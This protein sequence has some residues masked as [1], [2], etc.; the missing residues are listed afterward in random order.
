LDYFNKTVET[1]PN[2]EA[3]EDEVTCYDWR[4][5]HLLTQHIASAVAEKSA[6][7]KPIP[8][9]MEKCADAVAAFLGI[10]TAGCFYVYINPELPDERIRRMLRVLD[11]DVVIVNER[12][13]KRL[14]LAGYC[15]N[16]LEIEKAKETPV[17]IEQLKGRRAEIQNRD[18][19]YGIFTSGSTGIPKNVVV[20]HQAVLD[21][22]EDFCREFPVK[23]QDILGNQAPFDFDVSVKDIY[24]SIITGAKLVL[25][26]RRMFVEPVVLLDYL[27]VKR[28]TVLIWAASALCIVSRMRG[29]EYRI[30]KRVRRVM[31]SGEVMPQKQLRIW[32][33]ALPDVEFVNLYG[34][35]EVTCNC[36]YY[37]ITG[38]EPEHMTIPIGV[39]FAKRTVFLLNE[40]NMPIMEDGIQGEICV[41][42]SGLADGYYHNEK[43]TRKRFVRSPIKSHAGMTIYRTGDL[44]YYDEWGNLCFAGRKDFQIKRMGHRIEL[45]EIELECSFMDGIGQACCIYDGKD[46]ILFY[47]GEVEREQVRRFLKERLPRYMLPSHFVGLQNMPLSKNG[48]IDRERLKAG[49]EAFQ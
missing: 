18:Y 20:S 9:F 25:I 3:V 2:R 39:P 17:H 12:L 44:G 49:E 4:K 6:A 32:G 15:G 40:Y 26:P 22:M 21:F 38:C 11:A 41:G 1:F 43:E 45:Q 27:C 34:P 23:H 47:V 30:P 33:E 8:V 14:L 13:E 24:L 42:G 5:L 7:R 28:V 10:I 31:F 29:F 37:R 48:K 46:I 36:T 19:L 16:L 35:T